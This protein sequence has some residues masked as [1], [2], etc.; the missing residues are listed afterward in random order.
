MI[1]RVALRVKILLTK[2]E[3]D[4]NYCRVTLVR[5]GE[6]SAQDGH[7]KFIVNLN[8]GHCDCAY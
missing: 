7:T 8:V 6:Y 5:V 2:L 3:I 4:S 1:R